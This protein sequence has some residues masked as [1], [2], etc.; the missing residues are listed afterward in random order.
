MEL[1]TAVTHKDGDRIVQRMVFSDIT[2]TSL[3]WHWQ[4]SRDGGESWTERWTIS[5]ER[6]A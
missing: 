4:G 5:Y 2:N 6:R 1:R 3:T